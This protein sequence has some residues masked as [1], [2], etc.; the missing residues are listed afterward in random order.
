MNSEFEYN[1]LKSF[2]SKTSI[3][4]TIPSGFEVCVN[5]NKILLVPKELVDEN[6]RLLESPPSLTDRYIRNRRNS[7][8][9]KKT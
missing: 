7:S 5:K 9:T 6:F 1:F 2:H 3:E 8:P 4:I